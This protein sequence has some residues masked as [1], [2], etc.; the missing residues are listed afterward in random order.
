MIN[1]DIIDMAVYHDG[2]DDDDTINGMVIILQK[3]SKMMVT[4]IESLPRGGM[5]GVVHTV[6]TVENSEQNYLSDKTF[7]EM[8][9][10]QRV[11]TKYI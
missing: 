3:W 1:D 11:C 6:G 7:F 5:G 8:P 2:Y 10:F 4:D 9:S